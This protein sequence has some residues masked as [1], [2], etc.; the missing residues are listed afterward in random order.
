MTP[1][2]IALNDLDYPYGLLPVEATKIERYAEESEGE[3]PW[4]WI[5][6]AG[7][8]PQGDVSE[9]ELDEIVAAYN[10]KT[11]VEAACNFDH[12]WGGPAYG[13]IGALKREGKKLLVQF[14]HLDPF[15]IE[16]VKALRYKY[17]SPE[18][19]GNY[20]NSG[21]K[22][23]IGL[24]FLGNRKPADTKHKAIRLAGDYGQVACYGVG[25]DPENQ[26]S[27]GTMKQ[28]TEEQIAELEAQAG[29]VTE[30]EKKFAGVDPTKYAVL[31]AENKRL[32]ET[33]AELA[34]ERRYNEASQKIAALGT[35]LTPALKIGL[36][37]FAVSLGDVGG[38]QAVEYADAEQKKVTATLP[39][40]FYNLLAKL[41]ENKELFERQ[42][43]DGG[44]ATISFGDAQDS[45]ALHQKAVA[46]CRQNKLDPSKNEDYKQA[47]LMVVG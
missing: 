29:R 42:V 21:R 39:E 3:K 14:S 7:K 25:I 13:W 4:F 28:Y 37:E 6:T 26:S 45:E 19:A 12:E 32:T 5:F 2:P 15:L 30:L 34:K 46:Y 23:L 22:Y 44:P 43:V 36:V 47:L 18:I 27:E 40:F 24:A 38:T 11:E 8:Y 20:K 17:C 1:K 33:A 31:E 41:P 10:P 35:R 16:Q 9:E